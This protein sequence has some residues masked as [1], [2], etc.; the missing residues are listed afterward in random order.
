MVAMFSF[1]RQRKSSVLDSEVASSK[2]PGTTK[3]LLA[4]IKYFARVCRCA[5][6]WLEVKANRD[7]FYSRLNSTKYSR[8]SFVYK[9]HDF[10]FSS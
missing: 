8:V 7:S 9:L 2:L 6:S 4:G 3:V 1:N 5:E 10:F